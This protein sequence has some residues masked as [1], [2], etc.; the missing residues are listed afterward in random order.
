MLERRAFA[1]A[2]AGAIVVAAN[3]IGNM[4]VYR[5]SGSTPSTAGYSQSAE[6]EGDIIRSFS[7][8][9]E[10]VE[11]LISDVKMTYSAGIHTV[12]EGEIVEAGGF[13]Y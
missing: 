7:P 3:W 11:L 13:R 9:F 5:R 10:T 6:K 4:L 2:A 1:S 8:A 12:R